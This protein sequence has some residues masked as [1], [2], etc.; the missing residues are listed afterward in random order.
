VNVIAG[1]RNSPAT[2]AIRRKQHPIEIPA[3]IGIVQ[4]ARG[5]AEQQ[6]ERGLDHII[7]VDGCSS[8]TT[9]HYRCKQYYYTRYK[10]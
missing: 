7:I 6:A 8:F 1:Y 9:G 4:P 2:P 10:K 3:I 5:V